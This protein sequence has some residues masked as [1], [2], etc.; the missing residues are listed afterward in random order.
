MKWFLFFWLPFITLIYW[1]IYTINKHANSPEGQAEYE[2]Q[3]KD[4]LSSKLEY[5]RDNSTGI[6]FALM[7]GR[8]SSISAVDCSLLTNVPIIEIASPTK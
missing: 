1:G 4:H 3:Y 6:C 2:Q 5:M 7:I 8:S